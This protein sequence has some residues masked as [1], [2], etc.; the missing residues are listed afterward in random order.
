MCLFLV[1]TGV[2]ASRTPIGSDPFQQ[3]LKA[4]FIDS[5]NVTDD[6][7]AFAELQGSGSAMVADCKA[8]SNKK[9]VKAMAEERA[10]LH[11]HPKWAKVNLELDQFPM[12]HFQSENLPDLAKR[13]GVAEEW[14]AGVAYATQLHQ[15]SLQCFSNPDEP[16]TMTSDGVDGMFALL[17][18]NKLKREELSGRMSD[19]APQYEEVTKEVQEAH[20]LTVANFAQHIL[21]LV[22]RN[23][24]LVATM[25][26]MHTLGVDAPKF[27][28]SSEQCEDIKNAVYYCYVLHMLANAAVWDGRLQDP[29][30]KEDSLFM[31]QLEMVLSDRRKELKN[32]KGVF[33]TFELAK[34][35]SI[36]LRMARERKRNMHGGHLKYFPDGFGTSINIMEAMW[37]DSRTGRA[38]NANAGYELMIEPALLGDHVYVA[39]EYRELGI[40][41]GAHAVS[42]GVWNN[43]YSA[44]N[45]AFVMG[46]YADCINFLMKLLNPATLGTYQHG[47]KWVGAYMTPRVVTLFAH[48]N[49]LWEKRVLNRKAGQKGNCWRRTTQQ[50]WSPDHKI[51]LIQGTV[52]EKAATQLRQ[53]KEHHRKKEGNPEH[54]YGPWSQPFAKPDSRLPKLW[55][56]LSSQK[57]SEKATQR[58]KAQKAQAQESNSVTDSD[59][60]NA[61]A[62]ADEELPTKLEGIRKELSSDSEF[63]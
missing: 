43:L 45:M 41:A 7:P 42:T 39:A 51:I 62:D 53:R 15:A 47:L 44:W 23:P 40:F 29:E 2:V 19:L 57:A 38:E 10:K 46:G 1:F 8:P 11:L 63:D 16:L 60:D 26:A 32:E 30:V 4:A 14:N 54:W 12:A 48:M 20:L 17:V 36:N 59:D 31:D 49:F 50:D 9:A 24:I 28:E 33:N 52:N 35:N 55:S 5:S 18:P 25:Y 21:E 6:A 27:S 58:A 56:G 34:I 3:Q 13:A 61:D 37:Q 22:Q